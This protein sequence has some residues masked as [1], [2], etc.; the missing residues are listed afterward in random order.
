[1]CLFPVGL[2][3]KKVVKNSIAGADYKRQITVVLAATMSGKLLPPQ[4]VYQGKTKGCL[5]SV[6]FPMI[7]MLHLP[8]TIGAMR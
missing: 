7:G 2:W 1:M 8:R 4:L 3:Q 6:F 5:P